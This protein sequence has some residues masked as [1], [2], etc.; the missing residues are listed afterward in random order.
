MEEASPVRLRKGPPGSAAGGITLPRA[1]LGWVLCLLAL[2]GAWASTYQG[3]LIVGLALAAAG[4]LIAATCRLSWLLAFVV[5]AAFASRFSVSVAGFHV[6]PEHVASLGL[7]VGVLLKGEASGL[8]RALF[9]RPASYLGLFVAY[10]TVISALFAPH[11]RDSVAI[12]AW[13]LL[14]WLL[15]GA[16]LTLKIDSRAVGRWLSLGVVCSSIYALAAWANAMVRGGVAGVQRSQE[17]AVPAAFA[18]SS[19]ANILAG[20]LTLCAL[21]LFYW[22]GSRR[23]IVVTFALAAIPVTQT[24]AAMLAVVVALPT[25]FLVAANHAVRRRIAGV[26]AVAVA[27]AF[28]LT[29]TGAPFVG[30]LFAKFGAL[31]TSSTNIAYRTRVGGIA[32]DDLDSYQSWI[33]GLGVNS[34]GQRHFDP[35]RPGQHVA[36]YLSNLP[37][38]ILYDTGIVGVAT[39]VSL[40]VYC[41]RVT[42]SRLALPMV[43]AYLVLSSATS[44]FWFAFTWLFV[45]MGV[46]DVDREK[47]DG[48]WI[49]APTHEVLGRQGMK[50]YAQFP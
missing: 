5:L 23:L 43:L 44:P 19:E 31:E 22:H 37:L 41:L 17:S 39:V 6:R 30:G 46:S 42:K 49:D 38:Q 18:F 48:A 12:L 21:A 15:L 47:R 1:T 3:W 32:I 16:L 11:F 7:L 50:A 40:L 9:S 34:F 4:A 27:V 29:A 2:I 35:S 10:G 28:T 36:A 25:L 20:L 33:F 24:R 8:G 14:D 26:V 13:L 45:A